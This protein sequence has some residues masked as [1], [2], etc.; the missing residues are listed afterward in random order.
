MA[1]P[2]EKLADALDALHA[3]QS[4]GM[5]AINT[6]DISTVYR[7]RLTK[8][9]FLKKSSKA[10]ISPQ[11]L[12]KGQGTVH[13]GTLITGSFAAG[14]SV[15]NMVIDILSLLISLCNFIPVTRLFQL[16]W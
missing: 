6:N 15:K 11:V 14:L 9:G 16:S 8:N 7:Q 10:G 5:V 4:K 3:L 12:K 1:T 2:A 13:P